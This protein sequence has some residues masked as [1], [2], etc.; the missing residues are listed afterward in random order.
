M[1]KRRNGKDW[2]SSYEPKI[3]QSLWIQWSLTI[4]LVLFNLAILIIPLIPPDQNVNDFPREIHGWYYLVILS[5]AVFVAIIYYY[6]VHNPKW[7]ISC[8]GGVQPQIFTDEEHYDD[9]YGNRRVVR[10]LP[11]SHLLPIIFRQRSPE[12]KQLM[13]LQL[14]TPS[15]YQNFV[16]WLFGGSDETRHPQLRVSNFFPTR[17][18]QL[19]DYV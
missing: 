18:H 14:E 17:R 3:L 5:A 10:I 2:T 4:G 16:Y 11:V 7:S 1:P 6:A 15:F 8:L 19:S 12:S 13:L 9:T